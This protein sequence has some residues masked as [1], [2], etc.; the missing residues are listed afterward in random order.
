MVYTKNTLAAVVCAAGFALTALPDAALAQGGTEGGVGIDVIIVTARKRPQT[1]NEVP[2]SLSVF[3]PDEIED[4]GIRDMVDLGKFVPNLHISTFSAGNPAGANPVLRG[5]GIQDH[6]I[7]TDPGVG[8]YVDGVYLGR[9]IGQHWSLSN[10]ERVEVLRGPQGTLLGR[11]SIGGAINIVTRAPSLEPE[12]R[13][14]LEA[15]TRERANLDLFGN[16]PLGQN[17]A[18]S[19]SGAL[20]RRG[21]VGDFVNL[22]GAGWDVGELRDRSGRLTLLWRPADS[23]SLLLAADATSGRNGMNPYTTFIDELP[24]GSLF[25]TGLRNVDVSPDPYDNFSGEADLVEKSHQAHGWSLTAEWEASPDLTV[26]GIASRRSSRYHGGLD[27]DSTVLDFMSFPEV[28][29]AGQTSLELQVSGERDAL[30]FVAGLWAFREDGFNLQPDAVFAGGPTTFHVLQ[31]TESE[32][33][34]ASIGYRPVPA[35][36]I[37]AGLRHTEDFK[38]ARAVLNDFVDARSRCDWREWNWDLAATWQLRDRAS[39]FANIANGY[40]AGQFPPRPYC[41]FGFVD[42]SRPGNVSAP[43]CFAAGDHITAVNHEIGFKGSLGERLEVSASLFL[44]NYD[45][46]PLSASDTSG[47]GFD[48]R[49]VI[50]GQRSAGIE[51]EGRFELHSRLSV[52][53]RIGYLD[54]NPEAEGIVPL[55]SPRWTISVSPEWILPLAEGNLALRADYSWRDSMYG[56]PAANRRPWSELPARELL[57]FDISY[58]PADS[59][60]L[61]ALYG[62]NV[63]DERY[64]HATLNTGDYI[65][66]ILSN[67]ASEFG[68]RA[69]LE[70]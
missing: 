67:D 55:L 62:R 51:W 8:V 56:E 65:L 54:S 39:V 6:L 29:E 60:W 28:G 13:L 32:A 16:I 1:I 40:Q 23:L 12:V 31:D 69:A 10:I 30:D 14:A 35:L 26:K 9:Q 4:R 24:G 25:R 17:A 61:F 64:A 21:G 15:G 42:V 48:T 58:R 66:R 18:V 2:A 22:P 19:F 37:S 20:K 38:D 7:L 44:T 45:N 46:L 27:D 50:V 47:A 70:W 5:I 33:V 68:L 49:N 53:T 63:F 34:Y 59:N 43:N 11:N 41:L 36:R 52:D 3:A 57:N